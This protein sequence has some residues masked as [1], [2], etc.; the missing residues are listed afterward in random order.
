LAAAG[1]ILFRKQ[2]RGNAGLEQASARRSLFVR[3]FTLVPLAV[4]VVFSLRHQVKLDWTG[5]IWLAVIPAV[6]ATIQRT[7][8]G[9]HERIKG[10]PTRRLWIYTILLTTLAYGAVLHY[11]S[12]GLPGIG[13]RV[14][15][16]LLPVGW[17]EFGRQIASKS[18][19]L[20]ATQ[21]APLIVG[22]DKNFISSE[23]AFYSHGR[24]RND[25]IT[26]RHLFGRDSLMYEYWLRPAAAD[27]RTLMLVSFNRNDLRPGEIERQVSRLGEIEEGSITRDG[28]FVRKFFYRWAG[29][30]HSLPAEV[31]KHSSQPDG[32]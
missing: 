20:K 14:N 32:F 17:S 16:N 3:V 5:P 9:P 1:V 30:Y 8:L 27:G 13:Y 24:L 28:K 25:D 4:F 6:A 23:I 22:M 26:G 29:D 21:P 12:L 19:E 7:S 11:L 10:T 2:A 15:I 18:E 31:S